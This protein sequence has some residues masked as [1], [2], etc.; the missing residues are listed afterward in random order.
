LI[1][2][3]PNSEVILSLTSDL[4]DDALCYRDSLTTLACAPGLKLRCIGRIV[5]AAVGRIQLLACSCPK[6]EGGEPDDALHQ[7]GDQCPRLLLPAGESHR[8]TGLQRLE[9]SQLSRCEK[10]PVRV[11]LLPRLFT[12]GSCDESLERWLRA[13]ATG[14]RHAIPQT[15]A[16][17]AARDVS[18]L[19]SQS[20]TG[21]ASLL[22]SLTSATMATTTDIRG[23]RSREVPEQLALRWLAAAIC[24]RATIRELQIHDWLDIVE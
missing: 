12:A 7:E 8:S 20:R 23:I 16:S 6:N 3:V 2:S 15:L 11:S 24:S 13:I 21:A 17:S 22:S 18:K 1:V 9:K 4:D 19:R 5:Q 10:W 14:G